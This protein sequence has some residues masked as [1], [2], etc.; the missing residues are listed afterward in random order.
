MPDRT[1]SDTP[2][3]PLFG[4]RRAFLLSRDSQLRLSVWAAGLAVLLLV[5]L[6]LALGAATSASTEQILAEAPE[7]ARS[8]Q[9]R[10]RLQGRLVLGGSVAFVLGVFLLGV[11][12]SHRT[13]GA[14]F[15]L[16]RSAEQLGQGRLE[17]RVT[18]RRGDSLLDLATRFNE[19]AG[20]LAKRAAEE[21][22]E[23]ANAA[24]ELERL[25]GSSRAREVAS[26]LRALAARRREPSLPLG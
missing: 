20:E 8:L 2:D 18:L 12:E 11:L 15:R 22:R 25:D 16:G 10:D 5:P 9:A 21:E 3:L 4:R 6:N 26:R 13:A 1:A 14:A 7:L 23:L 19:M 24:D 17:A